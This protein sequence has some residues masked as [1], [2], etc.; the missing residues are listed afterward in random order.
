VALPKGRRNVLAL[1][2]FAVLVLLVYAWI[3]GGERPV[4][5][6]VEPVEIPGVSQ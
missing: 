4:R 1:A 5:P 3:D 2:A 6:I